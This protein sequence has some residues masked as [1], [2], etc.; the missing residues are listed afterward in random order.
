MASPKDFL[1]SLNQFKGAIDTDKV[2]KQNFNAIRPTLA[3]ETFTKEIIMTKSSAAAGLCDWIINITCYY[4]IVVSVEPKK[5]K[6]AAA[7]AQLAEANA[8]KQGMEDLVAELT[9]KLSGLME[10]YNAAMDAK[11]KAEAEAALSAKRLDSA[12]RLVGALGSESER[13]NNSIV[14]LT[15]D[16]EVVIG[17]VLIA[18]SFV[19]YVGPFNRKFRERIVKENFVAFFVKNQI[20]FSTTATPLSILTTDAQKA[21]WN[22]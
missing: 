9:L 1:D 17:D 5:I 18:S 8:K 21:L 7:Q 4:D 14:Q 19:S 16:I 11:N 10:A 15:Q 6:V 22:S 20:P 13:W 12:N 3:E 2:P